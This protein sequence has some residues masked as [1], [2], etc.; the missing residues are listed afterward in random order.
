MSYTIDER[1]PKRQQLLA[2]ALEP[3][4]REVLA[5][6]PRIANARCLDLGCGQGNTTRLLA[7]AIGSTDCIGVEYDAALV[8]Y[9][10]AQVNPAGVSFQQGDATRLPF[11][12]A[13]FDVVFCRYLMIHLTDP[14]LVVREMLRVLRPGGF[15]VAYEGDF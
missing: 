8:E 15:A 1:N 11:P 6:L 7:E 4:T 10:A 12:D 9:A 3:S 13:S 14:L 5:K 2:R